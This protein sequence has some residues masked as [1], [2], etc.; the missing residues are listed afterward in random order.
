[1]STPVYTVRLRRLAKQRLSLRRRRG[2]GRATHMLTLAHTGLETIGTLV[3]N[4]AEPGHTFQ[5]L[6]VA[7]PSSTLQYDRRPDDRGMGVAGTATRDKP[8]AKKWRHKEFVRNRR[9][10]EEKARETIL[11]RQRRD[12]KAQSERM[13][14]EEE[15]LREL[16]RVAEI[17]RKEKWREKEA[18]ILGLDGGAAA[19]AVLR[20]RLSA[21]A[22]TDGGVNWDKLFKLF[23]RDNNEVLTFE[24]FNRSL[25]RE[26]RIGS[27]G[28]S[29]SHAS[30][31]DD[32]GGNNFITMQAIAPSNT[33]TAKTQ[34]VTITE[35]SMEKLFDFVDANGDGTISLD[36][37]WCWLEY[38]EDPLARVKTLGLLEKE[39][40][41]IIRQDT[42]LGPEAEAEM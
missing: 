29:D 13:R 41:N 39:S 36:E 7:N 26:W 6:R 28:D 42:R 34:N 23:D 16:R 2:R 9:E 38:S 3:K 20:Q 32:N 10:V 33:N 4:E 8:Q 18:E 19:A 15:R 37:F 12:A 31:N 14:K 35:E 22:Y 24:E 30:I 5:L 40:D 27:A 11:E 17:A 25:R 1:M 21:A